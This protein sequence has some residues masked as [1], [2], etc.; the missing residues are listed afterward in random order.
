MRRIISILTVTLF[1]LTAAGCSLENF[2]RDGRKGFAHASCALDAPGLN[3]IY[4]VNL[5]WH[6]GIV[7]NSDNLGGALEDLIPETKSM[8]WIELGWGDRAFYMASGFSIWRGIRAAF[9][10]SG[11]AL[12]VSAF[13]EQPEHFF[14]DTELVKV[15]VTPSAF[16]EIAAAVRETLA[17]DESGASRRLGPSL[18]GA[19]S[20]YEAKGGF[21]L[22][23][24][25]N[26]WSAQILRR[27]GCVLPASMTRASTLMRALKGSSQ[28]PTN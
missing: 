4:V 28:N 6:T 17:I 9:F 12:H 10:S 11:T 14:A 24:T 15:A 27:A 8:R 7:V 22:S 1:S 3:F 16:P 26:S 20:F 23:H 21:S 2:A 19:G 25:C 5:G 18:Y 13:N